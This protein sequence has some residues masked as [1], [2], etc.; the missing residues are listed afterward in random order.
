MTMTMSYVDEMFAY[1]RS[2]ERDII[3][4]LSQMGFTV[5]E[6][7]YKEDKEDDIDFYLI[8]PQGERTAV[9]LKAPQRKGRDVC[10]E[11][12][13]LKSERFEHPLKGT[14]VRTLDER[15]IPSWYYTSKADVL[16]VAYPDGSIYYYWFD[17]LR[18]FVDGLNIRT[19]QLAEATQ[20]KLKA[21][22]YRYSNNENKWV[23]RDLLLS[24]EV[25]YRLV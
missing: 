1:G 20:Q 6:S 15:R 19:Q 18:K 8:D 9:S 7:S 25:G 5:E 22:G 11:L 23:P 21:S 3:Q 16:M 10:L 17:L 14:I 24:A 13:H 12:Y 2:K 4:R